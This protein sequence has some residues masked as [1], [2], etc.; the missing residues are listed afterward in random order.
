MTF[1]EIPL[2]LE[3]S[4]A[5]IFSGEVFLAASS[6]FF[7]RKRHSLFLL[8]HVLALASVEV[9]LAAAGIFVYDMY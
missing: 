6:A 7:R 4:L 9:F 1:N 5:P 2:H 8:R 3:T